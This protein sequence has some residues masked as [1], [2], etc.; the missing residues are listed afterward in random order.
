MPRFFFNVHDGDEIIRDHEGV[1]VPALDDAIEEA[2]Q[3]ARDL[4]AERVK[5][6]AAIDSQAFEVLDDKGKA[7]LTLPFRSVLQLD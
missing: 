2:R 7:V 5:H 1:D 3:A 4:L 6:G